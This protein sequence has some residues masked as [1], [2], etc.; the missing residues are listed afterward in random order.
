[1]VAPAAMLELLVNEYWVEQGPE[2]ADVNDNTGLGSVVNVC[3]NVGPGHPGTRIVWQVYIP[4]VDALIHRLGLLTT[5]GPVQLYVAKPT[6]AH[7]LNGVPV[8]V[9]S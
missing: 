1:M 3:V 4:A 5:P 6:G 7:I 9:V 8:H 2:F